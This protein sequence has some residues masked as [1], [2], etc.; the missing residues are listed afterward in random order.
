MLI[1]GARARPPRPWPVHRR[2][3]HPPADPH[4][5]RAARQCFVQRGTV[6]HPPALQRREVERPPTR[7]PQGVA[8]PRAA[9][10][11]HRPAYAQEQALRGA[12]GAPC[13]CAPWWRSLALP[14]ASLRERLPSI[15]SNENLRHNPSTSC[16]SCSRHGAT[17]GGR[18][19]P[20]C[21][22]ALFTLWSC[23][24][25]R[26]SVSSALAAAF[27]AARCLVAMGAETALRSSCCTWN[28]S[29]E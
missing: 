24:C 26:L 5:S 29:G 20:R 10:R 12:M 9:G 27:S 2:L 28:T 11:R 21:A 8:R 22:G 6:L 23:S 15:E 17:C 19:G 3:L 25:T 1:H 13:R 14:L 16:S 4:G 18:P 7:L